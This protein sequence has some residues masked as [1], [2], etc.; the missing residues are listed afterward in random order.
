MYPLQI[1]LIIFPPSHREIVTHDFRTT[2]KK[3][4]IKSQKLKLR[5]IIQLQ[6]IMAKVRKWPLRKVVLFYV[7]ITFLGTMYLGYLR[8]K[9]SPHIN[10]LRREIESSMKPIRLDNRDSKQQ[11]FICNDNFFLTITIIS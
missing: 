5:R 4:Y 10:T 1:S 6:I 9:G 3:L 8:T 2:N 7:T 11:L